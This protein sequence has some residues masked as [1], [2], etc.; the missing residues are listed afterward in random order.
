MPRHCFDEWRSLLYLKLR[1]KKGDTEIIGWLTG[2][3]RPTDDL[4]L[5]AG[6]D[7]DPALELWKISQ[8]DQTF[9]A[10]H[11]NGWDI[12]ILDP[13]PDGRWAPG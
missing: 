10:I 13:E 2:I 12:T 1:C 3:Y 11:P 9:D 4:N 8:P 5:I 7:R 6:P